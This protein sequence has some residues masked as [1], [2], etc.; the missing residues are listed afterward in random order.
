MNQNTKE[1]LKQ[2]VRQT[3]EFAASV[4][5]DIYPNVAVKKEVCALIS[6]GDNLNHLLDSD[7]T[8]ES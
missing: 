2:F 8:I 6:K 3:T 5:G 4:S 1:A 7:E